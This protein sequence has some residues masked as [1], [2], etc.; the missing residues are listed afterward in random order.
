LVDT[1]KKISLPVAELDKA[2]E[3]AQKDGFGSNVTGWIRW[4]IRKR[5]DANLLEA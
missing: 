3:Q 1:Q 5:C 4:V 2:R